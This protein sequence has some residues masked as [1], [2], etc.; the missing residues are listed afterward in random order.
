MF[1]FS[2]IV[3]QHLCPTE[4]IMLEIELLQISDAL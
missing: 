1:S 4:N 3:E 2:N